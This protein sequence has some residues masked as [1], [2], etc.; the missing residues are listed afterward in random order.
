MKL[1]FFILTK[2]PNKSHSKFVQNLRIFYPEIESYL[3]VDD[4]SVK[5]KDYILQVDD[6]LCYNS[7]YKNANFVIK[8]KVTSWD[9]VLYL[10][11]HQLS[12]IDFTFIV[13]D[14]VFIPNVK[15]VNAM[16][17]KYK[18]Y[19]LVT[20]SHHSKFDD[21]KRYGKDYVW[22]NWKKAP[23][24][25][26]KKILRHSMVCALGLSRAMLN[27][28]EAQVEIY[29]ELFF[30]EILFNS[31]YEKNKG[32]SSE[33]LKEKDAS[34]IQIDAP[35]FSTILWRKKWSDEDFLENPENWFHPVKDIEE[36]V[37]LR[38]L[39]RN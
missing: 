29:K 3:V 38:K 32:K 14:D 6:D 15:S 19:D 17:Q 13:E 4:N 12:Y 36:Q 7:N 35:E 26:S 2:T 11:N 25:Y 20:P 16:V 33:G 23:R 30:I 27:L 22:T 39:L 18:N 24:Y 8:K 31:L 9:K 5:S 10:L 1:G 34:L 21:K 28:V 37:R